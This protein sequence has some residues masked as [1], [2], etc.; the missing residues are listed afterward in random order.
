MSQSQASFPSIPIIL[1]PSFIK[2]HTVLSVG[3]DRNNN[4]NLTFGDSGEIILGIF[5][6][7]YVLE[8]SVEICRIS[9]CFGA[10]SQ[11]K[12]ALEAVRAWNSSVLRGGYWLGVWVGCS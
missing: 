7:W 5:S 3:K 10:H 11:A 2:S 9:Q 1:D 4:L 8:T 6:S 12:R